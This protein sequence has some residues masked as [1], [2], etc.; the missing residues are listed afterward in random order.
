MQQNVIFIKQKREQLIWKT[1]RS[2]S[3]QTT[4][5]CEFQLEKSVHE[6]IFLRHKSAISL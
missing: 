4:K 6:F 1:I 3:W 2:H 5:Y